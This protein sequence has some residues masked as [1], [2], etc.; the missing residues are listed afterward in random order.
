MAAGYHIVRRVIV[1]SS[2]YSDCQKSSPLRQQYGPL[3]R[4]PGTLSPSEG[5][6]D[7]V[8]G[9]G[10][11]YDTTTRTLPEIGEFRE[12]SCRAGGFP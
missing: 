1:S 2:D 4:P 8:R 3:T 10:L 7:R 11:L 6:R 5:E 9:I 12:S